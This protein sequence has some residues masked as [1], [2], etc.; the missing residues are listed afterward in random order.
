MKN[1]Y[2]ILYDTEH[3]KVIQIEELK[4][5]YM[6]ESLNQVESFSEYM[7]EVTGQHGTI[8]AMTRKQ[9]EDRIMDLLEDTDV[10]DLPLHARYE[11]NALRTALKA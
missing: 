6:N 5:Y 4:D 1:D 11:V 10:C 8:I 9:A 7:Q 2:F 3:D